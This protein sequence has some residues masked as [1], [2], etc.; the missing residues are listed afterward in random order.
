MNAVTDFSLPIMRPVSPQRANGTVDLV[1]GC[2]AV[3]SRT[4]I[5]RFYQAGCLRARLPRTGG[6]GPCEAVLL[7]ISGGIA[8]GDQLRSDITLEAGARVVVSGQ[9]AERLYRAL[10]DDPAIISTA[11]TLDAGAR[12]EYLPQET[13]FFDGFRLRRTLEINMAADAR[14]LGVEALVFGRQA[15]GEQVR[16]GMLRDR[17]LLRR[18]G[19]VL[20]RDMNRLDGDVHEILA[21]PALGDGAMA[22]ASLIYAA[23]DAQAR[24]ADLRAALAM[25]EQAGASVVEG[26]LVARIL[27]SSAAALRQT[28]LAALAVCRDGRAMPRVWQS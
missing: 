17:I 8:G 11:I 4:R 12:L 28:V 20:L 6:V 18:E 15:M 23:P 22:M 21:R 27:A 24:L 5:R 1:F 25:A 10:G 9:A 26:V 13:I 7:N 16:R 19:G 2:D 14:Y 3:T